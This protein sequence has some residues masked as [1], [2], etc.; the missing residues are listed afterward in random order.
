M[1]L[2]FFDSIKSAPKTITKIVTHLSFISYA[3]Y[4]TNLAMV[5]E[6]ILTNVTIETKIGAWSWYIVYWIITILI[7]TLI[8]KYYEKPMRDF[9]ERKYKRI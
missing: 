6:V 2:P 9:L 7:S 1:L 8:Y 5:C 3:I 4:L